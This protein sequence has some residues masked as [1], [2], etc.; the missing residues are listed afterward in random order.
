LTALNELP[1]DEAVSKSR[2]AL[3]NEKIKLQNIVAEFAAKIDAIRAHYRPLEEAQSAR[4]EEARIACVEQ[5][6]RLDAWVVNIGLKG[7]ET[8][9]S[10]DVKY[11][12]LIIGVDYDRVL[13]ERNAVDGDM[14]KI[15]TAESDVREALGTTALGDCTRVL[16]MVR[17]IMAGKGLPRALDVTVDGPLEEIS[18]WSTEQVV[19]KV[20]VGDLEEAATVLREHKIAGDVIEHMSTGN[21]LSALP[22]SLKQRVSL[23]Q[24]LKDLRAQISGSS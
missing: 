15:L 12:L 8:Y 10:E 7:I 16:N 24:A 6:G 18:K 23:R 11:A 19:S 5:Q 2:G 3:K 20:C 9:S 1:I 21:A 4:V 22:L 17:S 13:L 14:L